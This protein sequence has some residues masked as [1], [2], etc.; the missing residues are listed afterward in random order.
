MFDFLKQ[1]VYTKDGRK[2]AVRFERG[3]VFVGTTYLVSS[4]ASQMIVQDEMSR[5]GWE[6]ILMFRDLFVDG[7][8]TIGLCFNV[9]EHTNARRAM[10]KLFAG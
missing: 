4:M 5:L 9:P 8:P 3:K 1:K 10:K 2:F 7:F 6:Q